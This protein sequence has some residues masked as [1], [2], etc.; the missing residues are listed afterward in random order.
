[1][2]IQGA[3]KMNSVYNL[4]KTEVY[5]ILIIK[6]YI[7]LN[8][9]PAALNWHSSLDFTSSILNILKI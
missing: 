3:E 5:L 2:K 8:A 7:Q 4:S 9:P 1:L 6:F